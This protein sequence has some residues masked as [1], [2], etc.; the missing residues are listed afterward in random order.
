MACRRVRR[1]QDAVYWPFR[2]SRIVQIYLAIDDQDEEMEQEMYN[3]HGNSCMNAG[4]GDL[5]S[6]GQQVCHH[7]M[8]YGPPSL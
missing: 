2:T 5:C 3:M 7:C 6:P 8:K 4:C 1:H